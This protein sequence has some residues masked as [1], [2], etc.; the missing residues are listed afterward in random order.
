MSSCIKASK[1]LQLSL[2]EINSLYDMGLQH[3]VAK[4]LASLFLSSFLG[5]ALWRLEEC[6]LVRQGHGRKSKSTEMAKEGCQGAE[7]VQGDAV[8]C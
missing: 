4:A 1:D 6:S 5:S 7:A 8:R 3:Q 2:A